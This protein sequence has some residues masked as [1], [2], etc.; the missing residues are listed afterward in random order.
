MDDMPLGAPL[1]ADEIVKAAS[2]RRDQLAALADDT[3]RDI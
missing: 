3:A 1:V 2:L